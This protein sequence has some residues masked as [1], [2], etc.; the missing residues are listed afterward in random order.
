MRDKYVESDPV[1]KGRSRG[2]GGTTLRAC[3]VGGGGGGKTLRAYLVS[4]FSTVKTISL[5]GL[6]GVRVGCGGLGWGGG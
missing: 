2:M 3:L 4:H 5:D 1:A 6:W